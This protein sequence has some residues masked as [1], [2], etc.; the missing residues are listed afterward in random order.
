MGKLL[1]VGGGPSLTGLSTNCL[2]RLAAL[3]SLVLLPATLNAR[4]GTP[5]ESR[6]SRALPL[7]A[8]H[9]VN[10]PTASAQALLA[11]DA[12]EPPDEP[13]RF[14]N[15]VVLN[16][17]PE[18]H[19]TWEQLPSGARLWRLRFHAAG[20][21]DLNFGF[22]TFRLPAGA[23]L[24]VVSEEHD[25]YEGPYDYRD[26]K[27][28]GELWLPVVPGD[29]AVIEMYVPAVI[30]HE[31]KLTLTY[32]GAGY[33][34]LFGLYGRPKLAKQGS[35]NIDV[36]CPEGDEWRDQI[37]SVATFT[38]NGRLVC[39]GQMLADV[40]GT[41]RSF[42]LTA[43]HC[44]ITELNASTVVVYWNF[45]SANCGDLRGGS[46]SQNQTGATVLASLQTVDFTLLELDSPPDPKFDV[47]YTGWDRS[48]EPA[49]AT[50]GIH[51]PGVDEKAISFNDDPLTTMD[52]CIGSGGVDTHW[53]VNDWELGTTESGSSGSGLWDAETKKLI[54]TLSGGQAACG[55]DDFD[56]FAKFSEAWDGPDSAT[57][58]RDWLDPDDS[59]V[60]MIEGIE[61]LPSVDLVSEAAN[62]QCSLDASNENGIWEPGEM[63]QIPV[64]INASDPFT[65]LTG[66]LTINTPGIRVLADMASWPDLARGGS[67]TTL[68]PH[69][70]IF[71][72]STMACLTN[73]DY[74]IEVTATEGGPFVLSGSSLI[75]SRPRPDVPV[76]I[77]DFN[78]VGGMSEQA[79][80]TIQ[81]G[82]NVAIEDL[83]VFVQIRHG[84]VGDLRL[85]LR[86]PD[87]TVVTL[88]DRPGHPNTPFGCSD[89]DMEVL[90]SDAA[91]LDLENHCTGSNPWY[92][93]E[94]KPVGRLDVFD[95]KTSR[96]T[97]VL[98]A[99]DHSGGDSGS[100]EDWELRFDPQVHLVCNVCGDAPPSADLVLTK[101][102][103]GVAGSGIR[104]YTLTV[105]N[106]GPAQASGVIVEDTVSGAST[107][108]PPEGCLLD[109][110][111]LSCAVGTLPANAETS[112][113]IEVGRA[114]P[115]RSRASGVVTTQGQV[116]GNE[117]DPQPANNL[118]LITI[119]NR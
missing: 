104:R 6:S 24:H 98:T 60:M 57:R 82:A 15:P 93:G 34:D 105:R 65:N 16:I 88:L 11:E 92:A 87:G 83:Q 18:S 74:S 100:I 4:K 67:V 29:R 19:G 30:K 49:A 89:R 90:F 69:F 114:A 36:V 9:V 31:P 81:V 40:P 118:S 70:S 13:L 76:A 59:G 14:A 8:V 91:S 75:G 63:V 51:H 26:V 5:P 53:R 43:H 73:V 58:L 94:G 80:S 71:V 102:L 21:T 106:A 56:C 20:A 44:R 117:D 3:V 78:G 64:T 47:F 85:R 113:S 66:K 109:G 17:T 110:R 32:L 12:G 38:R 95:G 55:I 97:W 41:L 54:G 84:Y 79:E 25:Y 33:R 1:L 39:S 48:G 50:V 77:P 72:D 42:F 46:L 23:T 101:Q 7:T 27:P 45:E 62:D 103:D 10:V 37:R 119:G 111:T 2:V 96:G 107:V 28:H 86:G 112:Y 61:G 52:S 115:S 108:I 99:S 35:C 116:S 68:A 22:E